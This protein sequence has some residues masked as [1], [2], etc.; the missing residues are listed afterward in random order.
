MNDRG[1]D[2]IP[3]KLYRLERGHDRYAQEHWYMS[4]QPV[5]LLSVTDVHTHQHNLLVRVLDVCGA[6]HSTEIGNHGM[7]HRSMMLVEE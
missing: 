1:I 4:E 7:I 6:I 3:G 2:L 5:M